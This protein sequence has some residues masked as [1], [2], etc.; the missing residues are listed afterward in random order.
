MFSHS[1][2]QAENLEGIK[3][4]DQAI[5]INKSQCF[6]LY[7]KY[8]NGATQCCHIMEDKSINTSEKG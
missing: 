2:L 3:G 1:F 5:A 8:S 6:Y 7:S 4:N